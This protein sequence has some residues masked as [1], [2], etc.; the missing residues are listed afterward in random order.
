MRELFQIPNLLSLSRIVLLWP[1]GYFLARGTRTDT[2]WCLLFVFVAGLTDGLDGYLARRMNQVGRMGIALDPL[3]DKIFIGGLVLM[4]IIYRDFP[5]WLAAA[6]IGRDLAII[7]LGG[8]LMRGTKISLP[9]NIT[10]KY[11]FGAL[12]NLLFSYIIQ[13]QFGILA[14]TIATVTLLIA[15]TL[16][17]ARIMIK[18]KQGTPI[19]R[20][21]DPLWLKRFRFI[22]STAYLTAYILIWI[23][24]NTSLFSP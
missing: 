12:V 20:P 4:A 21:H 18:I 13:F 1:V 15:S 2:Y 6:V 5:I 9:S 8:L 16:L 19:K 10:G 3:A 14:A 11:T 24:Q 7:I 23:Y 17:Y 22:G